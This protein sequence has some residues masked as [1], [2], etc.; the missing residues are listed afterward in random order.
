MRC[1]KLARIIGVLLVASAL[2]AC[3]TVKLAYNNLPEFSYWWLDGYLDFNGA[4]TPRVRDELA[5]LLAWHRQNE[6]P[7]IVAL[8][9]QAQA[10][11]AD[12]F[13]PAQACAMSDEIRA[14]LVAVAEHAE[15]AATDLAL[16][17]GEAQLLQLE[18]K[19]AKVNADYRKDWLDRSPERQQEKRYEQLLDR[20]QDF[21]GR[22]EPSQR[23]LLK[24]QVA[25]SSFDP[26]WVDGERRKRQ[27]E[28]LALLRRFQAEKTPPAEARAA[29]H[30]YVQ[31]IATRPPG[32]AREQQQAL[33]QE[34]CRNLA[35]LHARTSASQ[36]EQA[37]RRLKDYERD[38]VELMASP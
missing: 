26:H 11:A 37:V 19:Y 16:S 8:L 10:L 15:P 20:N 18:R 27:Q 17:L 35:A 14:R 21:Y 32:P 23:E 13:T 31:R 34:G 33:L 28:T 7:K 22:L 2:A 38:L 5:Q 9:Q 24:E 4:Q 25:R 29:V 1:A 12:D 30:A 36:R 6:L 3:S